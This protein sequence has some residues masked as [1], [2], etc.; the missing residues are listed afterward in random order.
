VLDVVFKG[1]HLQARAGFAGEKLA[2]IRQWILNMLKQK[3]SRSQSMADKCRLCCLK[4][5]YLFESMG[6]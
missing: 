1:D 2:V 5:D 4:E 6:L 3:K